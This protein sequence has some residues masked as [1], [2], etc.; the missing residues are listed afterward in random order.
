MCRVQKYDDPTKGEAV[1]EFKNMMFQQ[2]MSTGAEFRSMMIRQKEW[3]IQD[4]KI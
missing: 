4:S 3:Q 1:S 2:K